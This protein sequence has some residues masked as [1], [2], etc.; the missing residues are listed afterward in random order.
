MDVSVVIVNW[1][2]AHLLED[3][4]GALPSAL[5]SLSYE[6]IVV[7][8]NSSDGSRE[9]LQN[10]FRDV[11]I[12]A[13]EKNEGFAKAN[14]RAFRE[15]RGK[16]LLLLNN[17]VVLKESCA[18][19]LFEFLESH[20]RA[21]MVGPRLLNPDRS[22]QP[23]TYPMPSLWQEV[24]MALRLY[25]FLPKEI[26]ARLFLGSFWNHGLS[27]PVP[28]L[29]GACLLVKREA[30]EEAGS[31]DEDFYFYGEIHDLCLR[32]IRLGWQVWFCA[33]AQALH[34]HGETAGKR[35]GPLERRRLVLESHHRLLRKFH[36]RAYVILWHL[37]HLFSLTPTSLIRRDA[38]SFFEWKW[39]LNRI[40]FSLLR[41]LYQRICWR[42]LWLQR[43]FLRRLLL[44]SRIPFR[45]L[46]G[47]LRESLEIERQIRERLLQ[48]AGSWDHT[49]LIELSSGRILYVVV[50]A[51]RPRTVLETGVANGASSYFILSALSANG[52]G[53]L[54]SVDIQPAQEKRF[55]PP[56]KNVGWLVPSALSG[57]W[58]MR[59]GTSREILPGLLKEMERLDLFFHDS[60]HAYD[61]MRFE[62][63][64]V[65]P[66]LQKG[67][68]L[69]SDDVDFHAL[70]EEQSLAHPEAR[71]AI[72][73]RRL[74]L[75]YLGNG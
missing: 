55:L 28:R 48:E 74:G 7:D 19:R 75:I 37:L 11:R 46:L 16:R 71:S 41:R 57:L 35:W 30:I 9:M 2:G 33:E 61:T 32:F 29:S 59:V 10:H 64:S 34:L 13:N 44:S 24:W 18:L 58:Q 50:R 3:C 68:W 21:A 31:L 1:N 5:G 8:N 70:F 73:A 69:F 14:N 39:T 27:R 49:G 43:L 66:Y 40:G 15:A 12:L 4:L 25:A 53:L 51:T 54:Y 47:Y 17:D 20:P 36:S 63:E 23:S 22:L 45:L 67:G 42:S 38:L 56:G 26:S 62:Y 65:W 6:T 72:W 60:D 52:S